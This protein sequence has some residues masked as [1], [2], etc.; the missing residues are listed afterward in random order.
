MVY[1]KVSM[2]EIKEILLR[3]AKGQSK[4]GIRRDLGVHGLTINRYIEEAK[5]LGINPEDCEVSQISDNL[6]SAIARNTTTVKA[7]GLLYPRD[8]VLLPVKDRIETYLKD[9]ITKTKIIKLLGR[10]GIVVS[11][12]S[13]LRF[14]KSHFSHLA[15]NITVRLPET[16]PGQYAQADF[17]RLGRLWD[18]V[19]KKYRIAWAFIVTLAFSRLMF[20][21]I[22]FKLD[23]HA[24]I[25]GCE[26]AW[27]YFGGITEILIFDNLSPVVDKAD[28]YNP[29]IN[30]TFMEYAQ[31]RGFIVDPTNPGHARGYSEYFVIPNI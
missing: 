15:K 24:V 25:Q 21:Y 19:T 6:C 7:K 10:D 3:I 12:S 9:G 13:F 26:L 30:K 11:E 23:S 5:C 31:F 4:R 8:I 17:G 28:R 29:R 22:T 18:E 20:V 27:A 14:V 16:E 2:I 1:R